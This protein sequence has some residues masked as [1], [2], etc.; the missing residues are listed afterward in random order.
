MECI[1]KAKHFIYIENQFF[2]EYYFVSPSCSYA[3]RQFLLVVTATDSEDKQI[4]NMIGEV[5]DRKSEDEVWMPI[6]S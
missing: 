1:S 2:S 4:K 5:C 3:N 6:I